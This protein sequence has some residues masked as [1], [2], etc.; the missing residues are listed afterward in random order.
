MNIDSKFKTWIEEEIKKLIGSFPSEKITLE[1]AVRGKLEIKSRDGSVL[2]F[3][4]ED[5]EEL[6]KAVPRH[7]W[8]TVKLPIIVIKNPDYGPS[9]YEIYC[10]TRER[11]IIADILELSNYVVG[12][13]LIV[14]LDVVEALL[15]KFKSLVYI[16]LVLGSKSGFEE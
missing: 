2:R 12:E 9:H 14:T 3:R 1:E 6:K 5:V 11:E 8:K 10:S 4:R 15:K 7:L 13:K 16:G